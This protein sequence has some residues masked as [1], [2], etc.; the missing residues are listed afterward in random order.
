MQIKPISFFSSNGVSLSGL[1]ANDIIV[2]SDQ[3]PRGHIGKLTDL[4]TIF[5]TS[6]GSLAYEVSHKS[7]GVTRFADNRTS[8]DNGS[9]NIMIGEGDSLQIRLTATG[10]GVLDI[11]WH[12]EIQE[13]RKIDQSKAMK[14]SEFDFISEGGI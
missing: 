5:T 13:V 10:S 4:N 3:I 14:T 1:S 9:F 2:K 6:G 11:V 7:G 8:N 12:G